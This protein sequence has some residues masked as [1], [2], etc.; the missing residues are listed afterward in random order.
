MKLKLLK[1]AA[2]ADLHTSASAPDPGR[3]SKQCQRQRGIPGRACRTNVREWF[4]GS[5]TGIIAFP[6]FG[7][8]PVHGFRGESNNF[9]AQFTASSRF[10]W[11]I[12]GLHG[13]ESLVRGSEIFPKLAR[14]QN[15]GYF[16]SAIVCLGLGSRD[17]SRFSRKVLRIHSASSRFSLRFHGKS[18]NFTVRVH[19][20]VRGSREIP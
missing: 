4:T 3:W 17:I 10:S 20:S 1:G 7:S 12:Q 16:P 2:D 11:G 19:Y 13:S 9:T 15:N 14:A 5:S 6:R 8:Q 18:H